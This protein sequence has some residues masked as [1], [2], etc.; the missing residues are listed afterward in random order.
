[1]TILHISG[2]RGWGGNE[3]QMIYC[4]PELEKLGCENIVFG[5][6]N[7]KLEKQCLLEN[8]TFIPSK[9]GKLNKFVN[10]IYFKKIVSQLKLDIIHLHTS[11]S[12]TFYIFSNLIYD[13]K[14]K[15]VFSKEAV[16]DSS[17]FLSKYKYNF[18][19]IDSIFCVS[20]TVKDSFDKVLLKRNK[21][22]TV[23]I[24]DC[25][26]LDI[27]NEKSKI[28]L[29]ENYSI[30]NDRF[31][32]GNVASHTDAKD[33]LTLIEVVDYIVNTL[34]QKNIIFIQIGEFTKLTSELQSFV[35]QK[36]LESYIIFTGEIKNASSLKSQFDVFLMTSQ[37]EGGP[38]SVLES[39][40]IGVP[41]VS[42]N[43]GVIPDV[44]QNGINGY[45]SNVKDFVDLANKVNMVLTDKV[46]QEEFIKRS[47][48]VIL[49]GFTAPIIAKEIFKHYESL[50]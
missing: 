49:T 22:K 16:S 19:G 50:L 2:A 3:Q 9:D 27:K 44:I 11:N 41:V 13:F 42:T 12:L 30:A 45:S 17:S 37:R 5:F 21:Q 35:E 28:N 4:I 18:S 26:S 23:V 20:K 32:V 24:H 29:R 34:N 10:V 15:S 46:V 36:K 14:F 48:N 43:V 25:V 7:S 33:L 40:L 39:M 31:I 38:S 47:K 8:I 1:M 6:E